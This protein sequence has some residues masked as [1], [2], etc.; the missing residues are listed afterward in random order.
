MG[1]AGVDVRILDVTH[2]VAPQDIME[3]AFVLRSTLPYLPED[4]VNLVVVDPGVGTSRRPVAVRVDQRVFIG[5]DNGLISL[6]L[7]RKTPDEAV[8]LDRKEYW[9]VSDPAPTFHGRDVFAPVAAHVALGLRLDEVGTPTDQLHVLHWPLPIDDELG[10]RGWIIHVDRYG[11]C[12]TNITADAV[13][14][15]SS[16]H[17]RRARSYVGN[18]RLEGIHRAYGDVEVGEPL[19]LI[20]SAGFVEIAVNR[21][22]ASTL[23]GIRKGS[24]VNLLFDDEG[25]S[26]RMAFVAGTSA[27]VEARIPYET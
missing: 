17:P 11:N 18:A 23:L 10:L 2:E 3:A 25:D 12:V 20:G 15:F 22:D 24:S 19:A 26:R 8:V 27:E 13:S 6:V 21:G 5:P 7:N 1:I 14:K 16:N 4:S 9:R